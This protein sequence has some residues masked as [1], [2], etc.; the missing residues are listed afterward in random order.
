MKHLIKCNMSLNLAP[1]LSCLPALFFTTTDS[2]DP[3]RAIQEM[4]PRTHPQQPPMV[5]K[6]IARGPGTANL[7]TLVILMHDARKGGDEGVARWVCFIIYIHILCLFTCLFMFIVDILFHFIIFRACC[8]W[9][10]CGVQMCFLGF[11]C[12]LLLF[13]FKRIS[14][15]AWSRSWESKYAASNT[16]T[17]TV[18]VATVAEFLQC[19]WYNF[20]QA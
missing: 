6:G 8:L 11:E 5:Q 2:A 17:S 19:Y 3:L 1:L 7:P 15:I 14:E 13:L 12:G 16:A 20:L 9:D 18:T 10:E 4:H